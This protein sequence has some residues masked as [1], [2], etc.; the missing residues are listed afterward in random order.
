MDRT[1]GR[2][3]FLWAGTMRTRGFEERAR[4]MTAN[5]LREMS[6]FPV[7]V[8]KA[9]GSGTSFADLNALLG[10]SGVR[11]GV[12]DP[13]VQ[14]LPGWERPG[15][16]SEEDFAFYDFDEREFFRMAEALG[17]D[18]MT[19]IE[20][21]G[22]EVP[23]ELGAEAFAAVCDRAAGLG[24]R[25]H[26]EFIPFTG[27]P[28]LATAWE[29]VRLADRPNGGLVFDTWHYLLGKPDGGLLGT[30]PGEKIFV[31][32]V[33]DAAAGARGTMEDF[34]RR[35][36]PGEGALDLAGLMRKLDGIGGLSSVGPEVFSEEY[37]AM[38]PEEACRRAASATR[39]VLDGALGG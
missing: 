27:I 7:D 4:G 3:L 18:S 36:A 29:I 33:S 15:G 1:Y 9:L 8:R 11:V 37:N 2:E 21:Y 13:F 32:Q 16:L 14:W 17:V 28:D 24:M 31:V 22:R 6:A 25:V 39:A 34:Y 5:G 10:A 20:P 30:I 38:A 23:A 19:V 12:L 26:L 35:L